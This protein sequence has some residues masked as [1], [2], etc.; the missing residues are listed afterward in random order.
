MWGLVAALLMLGAPMDPVARAT[1]PGFLLECGEGA[2]DWLYLDR[3]GLVTTGRG[4]L[5]PTL[6]DA[7]AL[8][9]RWPN[10]NPAGPADVATAW[11][12]VTSRR[13]LVLHGGGAYASLT[14]IRATPESLDHLI[15]RRIDTFEAIL[16]AQWP[17]WDDAPP[18]AQ[19]AL[20][21]LAWACG[22]GL[23]AGWPKLHAAWSAR[24][25]AMCA[26]ECRIPELD[27]S[28]PMANELTEQLFLSCIETSDTEPAP[29][30]A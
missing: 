15:Q 7:Q 17:G 26:T 27:A 14:S 12:L 24:D 8:D 9:W 10:G 18:A 28:E 21:R 30:G 3:K 23:A 22:P 16:R 25:W 11:R 29:P 19:S 1:F 6:A 5:L 13:D 4:N 20:M 2:V